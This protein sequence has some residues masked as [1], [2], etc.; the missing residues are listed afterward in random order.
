MSLDVVGYSSA[1]ERDDS[2]AAE[3]LRSLR[4]AISEIV[5]PFGGRIF[6]SAGDGFML[7]F[8]VAT[9]GVQAA[10]AL[11][12]ACKSPTRPLPQIRIGMHLGEVIVEADGDLLGHGVNIAARLQQR[13][14]PGAIIVS[15]DVRNSVRGELAQG[16]KPLGTIPLDKMSQRIA[17][18]GLGA[19]AIVRRAQFNRRTILIGAAALAVLIIALLVVISGNLQSTSA[20]TAVFTLQT[21]HLDADLQALADGI[22]NEIVDTMSEIGLQP[23]SRGET[24]TAVTGSRL[25]RARAL[26]AVYALD[27]DIVRDGALVRVSIRL[28]DVST[29][30]TVW[31]QTFE[32]AGAHVGGL[33]LEVAAAAVRVLRCASDARAEGSQFR[34]AALGNL[35]RICEGGGTSGD[36][37]HL[38]LAR[39]LVQAAPGSSLA[40]GRLAVQSANAMEDAPPAMQDQLRTEATNALDT[41]LR[42]NPH[43]G[44]ALAVKAFLIHAHATQTE[45]ERTLLEYLRLSPDTPELNAL[46][47]TMLRDVGRNQEAV[48]Y[49][50]RAFAHEPLSP[51]RAG[52][53]GWSLAI[54]G[55]SDEALALLNRMA[56][57]WPDDE[58]VTWPRFRTSVFFGSR[59]EA[60]RLLD[61]NASMDRA[62]KACW[63]TAIEGASAGSAA[64]RRSA[65]L[66]VRRCMSGDPGNA[67]Q[68]LA[69]LGDADG[70]FAQG[71]GVIAQHSLRA[72]F[73]PA[74]HLLWRDPRFMPLMKRAGLVDYWLTSSH[75]PDFCSD[76]QLPYQCR[77]E[78]AH[79]RAH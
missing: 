53:F 48:A 42:L 30:Q 78:A 6:S 10:M 39:E 35:L 73:L 24:N 31:A 36:A 72:F 3:G 60:L 47:G 25:E 28:D 76:A 62:D 69:L 54:V 74:A 40:Q 13:A 67:F 64:A 59:A 32:R 61:T 15:Q 52:E 58:D 5:A 34:D 33:R 11:L 38:R 8:P 49:L 17:I 19:G 12:E 18:Y 51:Y 75:W 77:V 50:E 23:V 56:A 41:A 70:A 22:A 27:G 46:Y 26:H 68:L 20:R 79:L 66:Q 65:A 43:N 16:L 2:A 7:E 44:T 45:F 57:R 1:A 9:S 37:E 55:R 21:S 63:R 14:T 4:A 29:H 71:D